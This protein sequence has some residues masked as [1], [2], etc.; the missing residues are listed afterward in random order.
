M[1]DI[2]RKRLYGLIG[3]CA[4]AGKI[5]SGEFSTEKSVKSGKAKLVIVANDASEK[6]K[7][8]FS[9][10]A[11]FR[12]I[13][14]NADLCDKDTLGHI[15]GR[16]FRASLAVEDAGLAKNILSLINGGNENGNR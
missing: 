13:P 11:E 4:K 3:I 8:R 10:M 5:R 12:K 9:D 14:F 7:K 16:E 2:E 15:I 1:N 6:T